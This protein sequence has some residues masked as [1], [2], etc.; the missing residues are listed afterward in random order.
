[1]SIRIVH[2]PPPHSAQDIVEL[3]VCVSDCASRTDGPLECRDLFLYLS[4]LL[5]SVPSTQG[6]YV[7]TRVLLKALPSLVCAQLL[8]A[9]LRDRLEIVG[10]LASAHFLRTTPS[11]LLCQFEAPA[12][13]SDLVTLE[14]PLFP[15]P[16]PTCGGFIVLDLSD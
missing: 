7:T 14:V 6:P 1:M 10:D 3:R 9:H 8:L 2:D 16:L 12:S 15:S 11:D 13:F 5:P 4:S